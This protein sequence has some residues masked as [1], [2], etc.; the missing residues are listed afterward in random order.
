MAR[1]RVI[2]SPREGDPEPQRQLWVGMEFTVVE[3]DPGESME[4]VSGRYIWVDYNDV[5]AQIEARGDKPYAE[6]FRQLRQ[7]P[8]GG[9]SFAPGLL[10]EMA[11][12]EVIA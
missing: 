7:K 5:I 10:I 4:V 12:C 2:R 6:F 8:C 1:V 3:P 9:A 11:A